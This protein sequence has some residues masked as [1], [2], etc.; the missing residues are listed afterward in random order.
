MSKLLPSPPDLSARR[1]PEPRV[2]TI[3]DAAADDVF[4]ALAS[5][6]ARTVYAALHEEPAA[7]SRLAEAADTSVQNARYHLDRLAEAGLVEVAG[8]QYSSKGREMDVYA[9]ADEPLVMLASDADGRGRLRRALER[10]VGGVAVLAAVSLLVHALAEGDPAFLDVTGAGGAGAGPDDPPFATG[11]FLGAVVTL[12]LALAWASLDVERGAL[13]E[14]ALERPALTGRDLGTSRRAVGYA[15]LGAAALAA[16]WLVQAALGVVL[17][18]VGPVGPAQ[19]LPLLVAG[20]A[21]AQAYWNDGLLVSWAVA[22][23]PLFGL[24]LASIGLGLAGQGLVH[25][26]GAIGY[27][28]LVAAIGAVLLGTIGFVA[29]VL[30]RAAVAAAVPAEP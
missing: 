22:F 30:A 15:L 6:T 3:D 14:W 2:L 12:T 9:P 1:E 27:P 10:L 16:F 8:T 19:V 7:A 25:L 29:G 21:A 13:A 18:P 23:L 11:V 4:E 28:V 24:G 17:Q 20:G 5:E 26:P